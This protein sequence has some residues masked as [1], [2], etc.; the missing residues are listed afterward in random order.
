MLTTDLTKIRHAEDFLDKGNKVKIQ[1]QFR[2][3]E[4]AHARSRSTGCSAC[5]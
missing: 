1:L 3:R 2:G 5:P 4:M